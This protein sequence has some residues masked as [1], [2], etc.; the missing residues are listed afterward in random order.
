MI[1]IR[2]PVQSVKYPTNKNSKGDWSWYSR[3]SWCGGP[4]NGGNC[5]QCTNVSFRDEFVHNPDPI[6]NDETLD[7]SYPPSSP[8]T[9]SFNQFHCFGY[10]DLLEDGVRCQRCTCKCFEYGL[11]EGSCWLCASR[12]GNSSVN[13]PVPNS[14]NDPTNIF[15]HPPKPQHKT[16]SCELCGNDYQYGYDCP[17]QFPLYT[18]DHQED[19]K[20]QRMNNVDDRWNKMIESGNKTIQILGEMILQKKQVANLSSHTPEPL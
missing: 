13:V 2:W 9:S 16:Y 11:R 6:L 10:E 14:F 19:L 12:D 3:C 5:R 18:I 7:F 4:F 15:T 8:Q 20:Q 17:P 1:Y